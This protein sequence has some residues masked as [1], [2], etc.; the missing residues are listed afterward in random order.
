[1]A[2]L[3][4]QWEQVL[5][6]VKLER[7][8]TYRVLTLKLNTARTE[9]EFNIAG[10]LLWVLDAT[11]TTSKIS[12]RLNDLEN[13]QFSFSGKQKG[14]RGV[15]H[16]FF[17]TNTAQA[18]K[19][20]TLAIATQI[21]DFFEP[22][23]TSS[24]TDIL[25]VLEAIRDELKGVSNGSFNQVAIGAAATQILAAN[26]SRKS[27]LVQNDPAGAT[28]DLCLGFDNTVTAS[29]CFVR[30]RQGESWS[31]DDYQGAVW[32]F[33]TAAGVLANFNEVA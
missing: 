4:E 17:I 10:S 3:R 30:L 6:L 16:R 13:D 27:C 24:Q 5:A 12:L 8:S 21:S 11:D 20:I 14:V 33:R 1:M 32:G 28:G 15:F 29:K 23:D 2:I 22:L 31:V 9:Q 26:T 18:G 25:T 19:E 7:Q